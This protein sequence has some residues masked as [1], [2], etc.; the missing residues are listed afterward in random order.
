MILIILI[1]IA[2]FY[3]YWTHIV[4]F[5]YY[6]KIL[7]EGKMTTLIENN[8]LE[9]PINKKNKILIITFDNRPNEKYVELHN[10]NLEE[11]AKKWDLEYKFI[12]E[13]NHNIYWC[14]MYMVYEQLLTNKYD[15]VMWLDSDTIIKKMDINLNDIVNK[16]SS[17]IYVGLDREDVLFGM[18]FMD[19]AEA[20][21]AGIFI[22]KNSEI[23]KSFMKSCINY[24]EKHYDQCY[25]DDIKLNGLWAGPCY[26]QGQMNI[27]IVN[28]FSK[29]TTILPR[30][31]FYNDGKCNNKS[32]IN[33]VYG[34]T[35]DY[36]EKCFN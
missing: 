27:Q 13:C 14:K 7:G 12:T 15:Y 24:Y 18:D 30:L 28:N 11:Y 36:R 1:V 10:K 4:D 25:V 26:E 29:Y 23:G 8:K 21:N 33:H 19:L 34:Q 6:T 3:K 16:Y 32:F 22:I 5:L 17:D 35:A 9:N 2:L 20:I 31:I